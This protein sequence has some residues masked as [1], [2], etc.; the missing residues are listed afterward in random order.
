MRNEHAS[1]SV[2]LGGMVIAALLL[3]SMSS[4]GLV[5]AHQKQLYTIGNNKYLFATGFL[6]EP[7]YL[8]DKSGVD[9]N[10]YTPDP[11]DPISTNSNSTNL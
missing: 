4:K 10:V 2:L 11:T 5:Y 9:L 8:D 3:F 7:V 1:T 6:N